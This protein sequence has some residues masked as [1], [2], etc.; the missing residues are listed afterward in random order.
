MGAQHRLVPN[1]VRLLLRVR[2]HAV[3]Q[4]PAAA[5]SDGEGKETQGRHENDGI[6][7]FCFLVSFILVLVN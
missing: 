6:E 7:G 3:Y 5:Y 4:L 2:I 1:D